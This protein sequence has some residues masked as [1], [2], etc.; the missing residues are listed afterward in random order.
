MTENK[1]CKERRKKSVTLIA[2][3]LIKYDKNKNRIEQLQKE[4]KKLDQEM[5]SIYMKW[6]LSK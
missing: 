4:N 6:V 1:E 3:K 2:E 5:Q